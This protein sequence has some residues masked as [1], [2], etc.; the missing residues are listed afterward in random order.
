V[1][2]TNSKIFCIAKEI[3]TTIKSQCKKIIASYTCDKILKTS[4][5]MELKKIP[6]NCKR[7]ISPINE[8]A[9]D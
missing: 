5:Y 2:A 3:V 4:I 8:W 1:V 7:T 6:I 9:Y